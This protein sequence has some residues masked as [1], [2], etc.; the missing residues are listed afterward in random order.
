[1]RRTERNSGE[2]DDDS[3]AEDE[4]ASGERRRLVG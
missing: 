1:M 2:S 4:D 3:V